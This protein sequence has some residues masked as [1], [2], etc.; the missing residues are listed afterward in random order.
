M[1]NSLKKVKKMFKRARTLAC[2]LIAYETCS[3]SE[4][5][6]NIK[7]W[8]MEE[9]ESNESEVIEIENP[10]VFL[11]WSLNRGFYPLFDKDEHSIEYAK[12]K[13]VKGVF[14][15]EPNIFKDMGK[16]FED[17][18][19]YS[20][21]IAHNF[22]TYFH[23]YKGFILADF[24]SKLLDLIDTTYDSFKRKGATFLMLGNYFDIPEDFGNSVVHLNE[25]LPTH[26]ELS[27]LVNKFYKKFKLDLLTGK[28]LFKYTFPLRGC[29]LGVAENLVAL[30][31]D[32]DNG[33]ELDT[34]WD[35]KEQDI[36]KT[37]GLN[38]GRS[39]LTLDDLAG[40]EA[41][42]EWLIRIFNGENPPLLVLYL[43]EIEKVLPSD[44]YVEKESSSSGSNVLAKFL[45]AITDNGWRVMI[46]DG[47]AGEGKST[48]AKAVA[49]QFS[50]KGAISIT[51]DMSTLKDK[52]QG[53][54]EKRAALLIKKLVA[55]GGS[56]VLL[57]G[58]GN[59]TQII[60]DAFLSRIN[61]G[62]WYLDSR[63][64]DYRVGIWL[65]KL[66]YHKIITDEQYLLM[67]KSP[68]KVTELG[69]IIG[70]LVKTE[71]SGRDIDNIC[72]NVKTLN[73]TPEKA[74]EIVIPASLSKKDNLF[75][76]RSNAVG[77]MLNAHTGEIYNNDYVINKSS[78][79]PILEMSSLN[80]GG[81][82]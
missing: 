34:L 30:S 28:D 1:F 55:I 60:A 8:I 61:C 71:Y 40:L 75:K 72:Y 46:Y 65:K 62:H 73:I 49:N 44:S 82:N 21:I 51:L 77:K 13:S 47:P 69:L 3:T 68:N 25:P 37:E 2:P 79:K 32:P 36:N 23:Q 80:N 22:D 67:E 19:D 16:L 29:T 15:A 74:A 10:P 57:I 66:K 64:L 4:S 58:A 26:E 17:L 53:E 54:A 33:I 9:K 20:V 31:F 48:L 6:V 52:Y 70:K 43:D 81:V 24:R 50:D 14:N 12:K 76:I 39:D 56:N 63:D 7:N 5:L 59:N 38:F 11:Q 35:L 18:P 27:I 41:I 45:T 42:K 78:D